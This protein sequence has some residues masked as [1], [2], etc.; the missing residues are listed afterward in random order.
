MKKRIYTLIL[1]AAILTGCQNSDDKLLPFPSEDN[2]ITYSETNNREELT[3]ELFAKNLCVVPLDAKIEE[4]NNLTAISTLIFDTTDQKIL[5]E[6]NIYKKIYPASITKIMTALVTLKY[7]DLS[8]TVTVS[9]NAANITESGAKLCGFKEGDQIKLEALLTAFLV[10]SGNDAGV[11][12]AEH[13]AGS[14]ENFADMMNEEAKAVGAV[15]S[16]FVNPHGLHDD[17]HYTT[18]YDIYLIFNE[19]THYDTFLKIINNGIV[20]ISY[21]NADG[22]K[23]DKSFQSTNRY[24]NGKMDPPKG[25]TVLGGK[26][27]T[28][29]KAG[30]CL[31]LY[32]QDKNDHNYI[33][34]VLK[35]DNGND[36]FAQ[37][38]HLLQLIKP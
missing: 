34:I 30:S 20:A 10:Y 2:T 36:L 15:D 9:K 26:T 23:V 32:S 22:D 6:D 28:T 35:A 37:M 12:I 29:N 7:A 21:Q 5:Y 38:T 31:V 18:A 16:H 11:A 8:D 25:I 24:L 19:L 3:S 13:I 17:N 4:D 27:G 14:V 1:V 33:S